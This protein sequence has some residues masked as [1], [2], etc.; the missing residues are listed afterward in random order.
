MEGKLLDIGRSNALQMMTTS[1]SYA[2]ENVTILRGKKISFVLSIMSKDLPPST[3]A[4]YGEQ[5]IDHVFIKK[6]D[7]SNEDI[8]AVAGD[9]CDLIE[10]NVQK[11]KGVLLH[12]A[13]GMSR[14]ATIMAAFGTC[15]PSGISITSMSQSTKTDFLG[16]V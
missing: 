7:E 13:M 10:A 3:R 5:S 16:I 12:C 9:V 2:A 15:S 1:R 8:L 4:A 11:G 14:S 6:H